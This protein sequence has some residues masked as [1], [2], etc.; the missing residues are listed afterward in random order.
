MPSVSIP[1][2]LSLAATGLSA[3]SSLY[4]GY[5][6]SQGNQMEAQAAANAAEMGKIKADQTSGSMTRRMMASVA[7]IEAVRAGAGMSSDS[8]TGAAITANVMGLGDMNRTAAM[9]N[10]NAQISADQNASAF[11]TQSASEAL[12]GGALGAAGS[13]FKGYGGGSSGGFSMPTFGMNSY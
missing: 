1:T 7:N 5:R 9:T 4:Q 8:P 6:A 2:A 10:V 13:I 12:I 11:Y 3:G